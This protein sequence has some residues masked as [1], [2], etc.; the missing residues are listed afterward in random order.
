MLCF[1]LLYAIVLSSDVF[2][3]R[4]R[5]CVCVC[6]CVCV[7]FIGI[8]QRSWACLTWKSTLEIKSLLLLL[9]LLS[10][11]RVLGEWSQNPC[12]LQGKNPLNWK[13]SSPKR[14]EPTRLHPAGQRA[15]HTTKKLFRPP[16]P[17][18]RC[19]TELKQNWTKHTKVNVFVRAKLSKCIKFVANSPHS[20][21]EF[22]AD[23]PRCEQWE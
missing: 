22:E 17:V 14:I 6:V 7:L 13:N 23:P 12:Y 21:T 5:V 20:A 18:L 1:R 11:E 19:H 4:A 3:A 10:S 2:D 15:Q 8:V 9:L 16:F